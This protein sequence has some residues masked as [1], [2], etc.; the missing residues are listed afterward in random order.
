[1]VSINS[2]RSL[3]IKLEGDRDSARKL[4]ADLRASAAQHAEN[5]DDIKAKID[6]DSA[7]RYEREAEQYNSQM[8][9]YD[10]EV[11]AREERSKAVED[12][13]AQLKQNFDQELDRL[14]REKD[15]LLNS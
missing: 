8:A 2:L 6:S 7:E 9:R 3:M 13:I 5:G 12:Q 15:N 1:M 11:Q 10:A 14:T 4:A